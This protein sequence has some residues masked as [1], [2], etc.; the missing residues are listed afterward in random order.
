MY[1]CCATAACHA[2]SI[3][4]VLGGGNLARSAVT[5]ISKA[6]TSSCNSNTHD[7]QVSKHVVQENIVA[8][9]LH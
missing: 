3:Q 8:P 6:W 7:M 1:C 2:Q 5:A 9:H 4:L